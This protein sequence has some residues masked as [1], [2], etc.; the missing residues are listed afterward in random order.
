MFESLFPK[1]RMILDIDYLID[2]RKPGALPYL[3]R[4]PKD[5]EVLFISQRSIVAQKF[6]NKLGQ[7]IYKT[8]KSQAAASGTL[9]ERSTVIVYLSTVYSR[10][11]GCESYS[12]GVTTKRVA[13][14]EILK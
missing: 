9:A 8:A 2:N 12:K 5:L 4:R 10:E 11:N 7:V 6:G 3:V 1:G 13:E 14:R